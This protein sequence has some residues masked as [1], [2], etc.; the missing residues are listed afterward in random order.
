MK[1]DFSASLTVRSH[2]KRRGDMT[3]WKVNVETR[4]RR[5]KPAARFD[6]WH[7]IER[8]GPGERAHEDLVARHVPRDEIFALCHDI[9][10]M[11]ANKCSLPERRNVTANQ[12]SLPERRNVTANQC[13][14][15]ERRNVTANQC[16]TGQPFHE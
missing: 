11:T 9:H 10:V 12:R 3:P 4:I 14:L 8:P 16:L 6:L 1:I 2:Q 13:S 5:E 7:G 15:P